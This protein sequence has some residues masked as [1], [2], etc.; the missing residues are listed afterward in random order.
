MMQY[1]GLFFTIGWIWFCLGCAAPVHAQAPVR[2]GNA[3][4]GQQSRDSATAAVSLHR[5]EEIADSS[6]N[7]QPIHELH[8]VQITGNREDPVTA[9][10][11]RITLSAAQIAAL[12]RFFGEPDVLKALQT[13]P[14][15]QQGAEGTSALLVR[16]G[17][18]DQ[19]LI[20]LDGA[21]LYNPSH[22]LG[23]FSSFNAAAIDG[24]TLYKGA[25]PARFGGRISSVVDISLKTGDTGRIGG[26]ISLGLLSSSLTLEGPLK[27]NKTTFLFSGRRTYHDLYGAPVIRIIEPSVKK[28]SLYFYDFNLKLEH[29][30]S[31]KDQLS[32]SAYYGGDH[33]RLKTLDERSSGDGS[34]AA[35]NS[36]Q[37]RNAFAVLRW[38]HTFSQNLHWSVALSAVQYQLQLGSSQE[39]IFKDKLSGYDLD[40]RSGIRDYTARTDVHYQLSARQELRLG[41]M[42]TQHLFRPGTSYMRETTESGPVRAVDIDSDIPASEADLYAEDELSLGEHLKANLGLHASAFFVQGK[43]YASLQPRLSLRY[44]LTSD[45]SIK[46]SYADMT[47]Y[48]HLLSANSIA[49]PTDLWVPATRNI[50]PQQARQV[51]LGLSGSLW[52][53]QLALTAEVYYKAM[54]QVLEYKDGASYLAT[55]PDDNWEQKV[56]AG[57]GRAYGAEL[58]LQKTTGRVTGWMSYTLAWSSRQIPGVNGG[59]TFP[60]K[61]DRRHTLN[62]VGVFRWRPGIEL[63]AAFIYQSASPYTIPTQQYESL[64]KF[65]T[66]LAPDMIQYLPGRNNIR[67]QANHRLDLA[68]HFIKEKANGRVR[69][70]TLSV[71]NVY[72][73]KNLFNYS[74]DGYSDNRVYISGYS[75][76]PVL[77]SVSWS[78]RF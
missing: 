27:K 32:L 42:Y 11:S 10:M 12:P 4:T 16:G 29:H 69:T 47:Q 54:D 45:W 53:H 64:S 21:P 72:N 71:Y 70:W 9:P 24:V 61:Y 36:L 30:L 40:L 57:K 50:A 3:G 2:S 62:L 37:W 26:N 75:L 28:V 44:L 18:P 56:A 43:H 73:R 49:L 1:Y 67:I 39:D 6:G 7:D 38:Q 22:L 34:S 78:F 46:A 33:F 52:Q 74:V 35:D 68:I 19:N 65:G 55:D 77:P 60:Y 63:S 13:L 66:V 76:L 51:A 41:L 14:G 48:L 20:L 58:F 25:F 5:P 59:Q 17:T 23:I 8:G 15:V 31:A